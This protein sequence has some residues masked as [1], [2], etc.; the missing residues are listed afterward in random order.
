MAG[1]RWMLREGLAHHPLRTLRAANML[2]R[3]THV[4]K[5]L[6]LSSFPTGCVRPSHSLFSNFLHPQGQTLSLSLPTHQDVRQAHPL[7]YPRQN[8]SSI[9]PSANS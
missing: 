5:W 2:L 6:P 1:T 8:P 3:T 9:P 4:Q 7:P